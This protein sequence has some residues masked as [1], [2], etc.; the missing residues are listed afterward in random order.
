MMFIQGVDLITCPG[1][2]KDKPEYSS[3]F[4]GDFCVHVIV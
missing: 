4:I 2:Y 1:A 3:L